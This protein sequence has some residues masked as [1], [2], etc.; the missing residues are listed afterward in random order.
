MRSVDRIIS[1]SKLASMKVYRRKIY[2]PVAIA[3]IVFAVLFS[4]FGFNAW[5]FAP[6]H[7][8]ENFQIDSE[9]LVFGRLNYARSNGVFSGSGLLG[10]TSDAIGHNRHLHERDLFNA[11]RVGPVWQA[12][13]VQIGLQGIALSLIDRV[14]KAPAGGKSRLYKL[15]FAAATAISIVW[16]VMVLKPHIGWV[17]SIAFAAGAGASP[18]LTLLAGNLY[19][20]LFLSFLPIAASVRLAQSLGRADRK[21][22]AAWSWLILFLFFVKFASG[23][24]F[25]TTVLLAALCGPLIVGIQNGWPLRRLLSLGLIVSLAALA[26]FVLAITI[27]YLQTGELGSMVQRIVDRTQSRDVELHDRPLNVWLGFA[28]P[29]WSVLAAYLFQDPVIPGVGRPGPLILVAICLA[30]IVNIGR[31]NWIF[32]RSLPKLE[33]LSAATMLSLVGSL[34]WLVLA[35]PHS[36]VHHHLVP[37]IWSIG[38]IPFAYALF[39]V[40]LWGLAANVRVL[41]GR[42][43]QAMAALTAGAAPF[44]F[45]FFLVKDA[46]KNPHELVLL[47]NMIEQ[48]KFVGR[49]QEAGAD[50]YLGREALILRAPDCSQLNPGHFLDVAAW[51]KGGGGSHRASYPIA[52]GLLPKGMLLSRSAGCVVIR[53]MLHPEVTRLQL[54]YRAPSGA[55]LW[56]RDID[57]RA[58]LPS[59]VRPHP[60][61]DPNWEAGYA[62][63]RAG[64]VMSRSQ[65]LEAEIAKGDRIADREVIAIDAS[66][67][68]ANVWLSGPILVPGT[69]LTV[70]RKDD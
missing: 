41:L 29:Q 63:G 56:S 65:Y 11:G 50:A 21:A 8:F 30:V 60:I 45:A 6:K 26:A 1:D 61:T 42:P 48:S 66:A 69:P 59:E 34:S 20:A 18:W 17:G 64:F 14:F 4:G 22:A 52:H 2:S 53:G 67:V 44:A 3:F 28:A 39:A 68:Y 37:I 70:R 16:I 13:P 7:S 9:A 46:E 35:K 5:K 15:L 31:V 51:P 25:M 55:V 47:A 24:E 19:F 58:L 54:A 38:F 57:L 43:L 27:Q 40:A 49:I 62:R 12:Y 33:A 32:G 10:W 23:Y 36:Y